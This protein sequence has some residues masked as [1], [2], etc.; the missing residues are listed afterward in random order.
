MR[1]AA[2]ANAF[3]S[4]LIR[5]GV[6]RR[7]WFHPRVRLFAPEFILT[8]VVRH[9]NGLSRKFRGP[10]PEF[11]RL[12]GLLLMQAEVVPDAALKPFLH[13]AAALT[14]DPDDWLYLACALY[15][16]ADLWSHDKGF[17]KQ[18]RVKAWTTEELG[19]EIGL[20]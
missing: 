7:L 12:R 20:L 2:D 13:A 17:L 18:K 4:A 9:E 8:E 6:T 3:I 19:R 14:E 10:L 15:A 16:D 11:R 1:L 5:K